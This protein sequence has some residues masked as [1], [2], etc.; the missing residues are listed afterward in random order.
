MLKPSKR[1]FPTKI[2]V[3]DHGRF[4]RR[5]DEGIGME[6]IYQKEEDRMLTL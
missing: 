4:L 2:V 5:R 6:E 3:K 1:A